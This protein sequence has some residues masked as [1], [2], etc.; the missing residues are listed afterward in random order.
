MKIAL[1]M[2]AKGSSTEAIFLEQCLKNI[3]P[4]V[5]DV[6]I[7]ATYSKSTKEID[8]I[9]QIAN[10]YKAKV[11][12]FQWVNDFS[13][14]RNF[15]FAQ[16]PKDYDYI[17][18]CDADD[19][20][21]GL[22]DLKGLIKENPSI[23]AFA[24][25]YIYAFDEFNNPVDVHKKTMLVRNDDCVTWE[26]RIHENFRENRGISTKFVPGIRRIHKSTAK[27]LEESRERNLI[28]AEIEAKEKA[29]DPKTLFNLG[30][31][32]I[33][34]GKYKK[35]KKS[36]DE[37]LKTSQSDEEKY[38][39]H[40][41]LAAVENCLGN[42]EDSLKNLQMAIG[43]HPDLPDAYLEMGYICSD[44]G[45]LDKAE[46]MFL[47]GLV[48][49]PL[50]NKLI[51]YNPRDYDY[52]PLRALAKV[53]F[54]KNRPDLALPLLEGCVTI[55]P[56]D[57]IT[58]G[59]VEELQ[60][61]VKRMERVIEATKRIQGYGNDKEKIL[62]EINK[63]DD[64]LQSHP[65]I[66]RV[67][68]EHFIKTESNGKEIA[69]YCG[70]TQHIWNPE[71]AKTKGIGGSEEA[72][73]NLAKEWVS[74]GYTVTVFNSC[75]PVPMK[76]DGVSY[77]PYWHYSPRDKYDH[78]ILWRTPRIADAELNVSNIYV[79]LHDVI[80]EGE[81]TEKRLAKIKKI[82]VK[83]NAHR[84]LFPNISDDKFAIIPNGQDFNLFDQDIKKDPYLLINT[85][86]PD[87]SM[88][89]LPK[90]FKEIKKQ[91]PQVRLKWAYGFDIFDQTF[92]NDTKKME[93]R[94]N[95]L[96]EMEEAGI[97]NMGRLSQKECAKLYQEGRILA[98]PSEFYE[99]DCISLKKAQACGCKPITTDFA[100]FNES[101][102]YGIKVHSKK[103]E[104]NW[105]LP[106]QFSFG[107]QDEK[108]QKDWVNAVV[109]E[110]KKPMVEEVEMKEWT[111]QFAWPRIASWWEGSFEEPTVY[112]RKLQ[113]NE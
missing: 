27:H 13:A 74:M 59:F 44:Y 51:V 8:P 11:S 31:A 83:T 113:T 35:A 3:S 79:D 62:F 72:V 67:R 12:S 65:E 66:C 108:T 4:Y 1:A 105:S 71:M 110:L 93:W 91:V 78:L 70:Q 10:K 103:T 2:I 112:K 69:Y 82:F 43:L 29:D 106:Y 63:L 57:K 6:F 58:K 21:D 46:E 89:V 95:L 33:G 24:F 32:L 53:Y 77:K 73:I 22:K 80:S 101:N 87:R 76:A 94:D 16:V 34:V 41:R 49:R 38:I 23:D 37:F 60:V 100:A 86:S 75:G 9:N 39:I 20:Y 14:A 19:I 26:N 54:N 84:V 30:N 7:T 15:N 102:K 18:W 81:F 85:S 36:F 56:E 92:Q 104:D 64:D 5:D 45:M 97:E 50:Y 96:K 28:V 90:L 55:N 61:E 42:K 109:K 47:M 40:Q 107:I 111:K 98:Y 88:D 52:K 99:I 17:L 25:N 48:K 68:N